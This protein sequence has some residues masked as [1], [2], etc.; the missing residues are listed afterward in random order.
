MVILTQKKQL[1]RDRDLWR[2][3]KKER[4]MKEE[5]KSNY[6]EGKKQWKRQKRTTRMDGER[7]V[8][9]NK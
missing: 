2:K 4:R 8:W 7:E 9:S 6:K 5:P 3:K 1:P